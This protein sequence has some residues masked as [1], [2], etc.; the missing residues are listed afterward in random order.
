[1]ARIGIVLGAGGASGGGFHAGVLTALAEH[2][3]WDPRT[4]TV[5]VGTSAGSITG[6][7][8]RAGLPAPDLLARLQG[9]RLSDEGMALL[10]D[11]AMVPAPSLGRP[12]LRGRKRSAAPLAILRAAARPWAAS[13]VAVLS[14]LL[15]AGTVGTEVI[16]AM[17]EQLAGAS[18]PAGDLRLCAVR[19]ADGRRRVFT[20]RSSP[21]VPLGQAVAASCAIPSFFEPVEIDGRRYVDG[22]VHSPTNLDILAREGLDLVVVSSPMSAAGRGLRLSVDAPLRRFSRALLDVEAARVRR[23]G[24][25]VVAFQPTAADQQV[26]GLN[27]MDGSRRRTVAEHVRESTLRRL[28]QPATRARLEALY[29]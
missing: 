7:I 2:T 28:D 18:W 15:P 19:L 14:S 27:P 4:A 17:V 21:P 24:T 5:I 3:G 22:G 10:G 11:M 16:S 1:M 25:P 6:T 13:P 23:R 8:L 20:S 9:R 26:M 12:D 29:D